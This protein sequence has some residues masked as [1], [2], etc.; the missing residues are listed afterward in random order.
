MMFRV[1]IIA[2]IASAAAA[3]KDV[4]PN[5]EVAANS[6][7]GMRLL[8]EAQVVQPARQ[9]NDQQD[10][11]D[12]TFVAGYSLRYKGC[13]S[14]IQVAAGENNNN[15]NNQAESMLYAT[16]LARFA[17]CPTSGNCDKCAGGGEYVMNMQTFVDAFTEAR[18]TE[19]EY[20]CETVRENCDCDGNDDQDTCEATCYSNAGLTNCVEDQENGYDFE[21]QRYL[22]CRRK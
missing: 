21:I 2:L 12:V 1:A 20:A 14:L 6:A 5:G 18:L 9:L 17:L 15:K 4:T 13:H 11:R 19:A 8:S 3:L 10:E 22:E 16:H 7:L